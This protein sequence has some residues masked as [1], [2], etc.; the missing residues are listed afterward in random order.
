MVGSGRRGAMVGSGR[1]GPGAI[2]RGPTPG[3][4][5]RPTGSEGATGRAT[6]VAVAAGAT[7][8]S[9]SGA[10]AGAALGS[11]SFFFAAS[12][13]ASSTQARWFFTGT[14]R[15]LNVVSKSLV[16][17]FNSLAILQTCTFPISLVVPP[18]VLDG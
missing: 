14:P 13:S 3:P 17:T 15:S 12:A 9:G 2:G 1:C 16:E 5:G 11:S 6:G 8:T 18:D 10:G 7:F 4:A